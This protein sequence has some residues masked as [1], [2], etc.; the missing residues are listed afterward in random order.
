M[1]RS[2]AQGFEDT[3]Q[4]FGSVPLYFAPRIGVVAP[5]ATQAWL[6]L[7]PGEPL[8]GPCFAVEVKPKQAEKVRSWLV[9]PSWAAFKSRF[10]RIHIAR[11]A[12]GVVRP[13]SDDH[14]RA[15]F[16]GDQLCMQH[17]INASL[18]HQTGPVISCFVGGARIMAPTNASNISTVVAAILAREP[19]LHRLKAAQQ[20]LDFLDID[21][22]AIVLAAPALHDLDVEDI[23]LGRRSIPGRLSQRAEFVAS[24]CRCTPGF[25]AATGPGAREIRRNIAIAAIQ[26][27]HAP[28]LLD[29]LHHWLVALSLDDVSIVVSASRLTSAKLQAEPRLQASSHSGIIQ[30]SEDEAYAY[31][32]AVVDAG[33]KPASKLWEKCRNER[34]V[35]ETAGSVLDNPPST[36]SLSGNEDGDSAPGLYH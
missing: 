1:P 6:P 5:D 20:T 18:D 10:S 11:A 7:G 28:D 15:L 30:L 36:A 3:Y 16:S 35:V 8:V 26:A 19:L 23:I 25:L 32:I 14:Y 4:V 12:R 33:L 9:E 21:G 24:I 13:Q 22:V 27:L 2:V 31:A 29:L 34:I 17:A